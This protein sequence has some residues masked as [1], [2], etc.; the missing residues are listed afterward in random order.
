MSDQIEHHVSGG[1]EAQPATG[2][3]GNAGTNGKA[4]AALVLGIVGLVICPIV[5]S[6]LAI[7]FGR[8]AKG[9]IAANPAMEGGG[10]AQAGY[11]MGIV[12]T[13]VY[14]AIAVLYLVI[15]IILGAAASA[16]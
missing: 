10:M 2:L 7:I 11:I 1:S 12:G 14:G 4:I 8:Q 3:S 15:F 16:S 5:C 9:E 13:A 6:I